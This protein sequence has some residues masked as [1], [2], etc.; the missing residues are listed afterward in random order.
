MIHNAR[1]TLELPQTSPEE[2]LLAAWPKEFHE[3]RLP[4]EAPD[5]ELRLRGIIGLPELAR[6]TPKYQ[7]LYLNGRVIRDRF[8]QHALREAFRGLTEPGRHPAAVLM[9]DIP[10]ADVDVNVHP[11]KSEV[12]FR[13]G[14]RIHGLVLS[15]VRERLLGSDLTPQAM[16]RAGDN[17]DPAGRQDMRAK[18]AAFFQQMPASVADPNSPAPSAVAPTSTATFEARRP[19]PEDWFRPQPPASPPLPMG[20]GRG[21]GAFEHHVAAIAPIDRTSPH[22]NPLPEG[23][24]MKSTAPRSILDP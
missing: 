3:Q 19:S 6:P 20:E 5:A 15:A 1:K 9:L 14:G 17:F 16:P 7:F 8:I 2:R 12:R 24:G 4:I 13:D 23:E 18:L 21:E 11:T 22:P 10:P